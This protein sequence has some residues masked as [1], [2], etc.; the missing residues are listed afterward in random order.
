[1]VVHADWKQAHLGPERPIQQ[2]SARFVPFALMALAAT[3]F[4]GAS[5]LTS[6]IYPLRPDTPSYLY[7]D[8]SRPI[9]YPVFLWLVGLTGQP[10]WAI[11]AQMLILM[12]SLFLLGLAF[13]SWT[14]NPVLAL[15]F[16]LAV[17]ASPEMWK[18]SS[19]LLTE[20]LATAAVCLWCASLLW[21]SRHPSLK[22]AALLVLL[23]A[24]GALVKP[25]LVV[26]FIAS[27]AA[28]LL[29]TER[30]HRYW[31]GAIAL[32]G[33]VGTLGMTPIAH[34]MLHGSAD[35]GSPLARGVLQHTLFCAPGP[36]PR[37]PD[38]ELVESRARPVREYIDRA[39]PETRE[40]MKR[41]YTGRLRFG[42]IIPELGRRHGLDGGWQVDE[43]IWRIAKERIAGNPGCYAASVFRT[44]FALATY[45][46]YSPAEVRDLV[47]TVTAGPPLRLPVERP[48]PSEM[49]QALKAADDLGFSAPLLAGRK[50]FET[51]TGRPLPLIWLARSLYGSA[52]IIGLLAF[53]TLIFGGK[54][55]PDWRRATICVAA[56]G[57]VFHGT[58]GLTAL[59][60]LH[61]NRYLVPLWP[62]V[63]TILGIVGFHM[64]RQIWPPERG[65]RPKFL[66]AG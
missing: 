20:A 32:L 13:Y 21:M 62:V 12:L 18:Y 44:Y 17:V 27:I 11:E 43:L 30:K 53:V 56:L 42:M 24:A 26:M 64:I 66:H 46:S 47:Q 36:S 45:K 8:P 10:L 48:L 22:P 3:A 34:L 63:C 23:S 1:M 38:S 9:G 59:V 7:F 58:L 57:I 40:M 54:E 31:G 25:S 35:G 37:D 29:L 5:W 19:M 52:A 50:E 6:D 33:L 41:L 4:L 39:P 28:L 2:R 49:Q 60:E 65:W 55:R 51:P 15:L 61:L 16:Q 14:G